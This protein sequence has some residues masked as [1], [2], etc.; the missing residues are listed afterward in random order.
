MT[1][2]SEIEQAAAPRCGPYRR[3]QQSAT[4]ASVTSQAYVDSLRSSIPSGGWENLFI[5]RRSASA[6]DRQ[7]QVSAYDP[8]T[9][10][11]QVDRLWTVAPA[12]GEYLELHHLDPA[13]ELRP[14]VLAGLRRIFFEARLNVV[15]ASTADVDLT[16]QYPWLLRPS[17]VRGLELALTGSTTSRAVRAYVGSNGHVFLSNPPADAI[18][19][20][21]QITALRPVWS[22]VNGASSTTGPTN[23]ADDLNVDADHAAAAAHIE[24]WHLFPARMRQAAEA[25]YQA[26][27]Q[28]AAVEFTRV[29]MLH[30]Q[31]TP[32]RFELS[33][34]W[35]ASSRF[36]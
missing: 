32:R 24:A 3:D 7:R 28:D 9:G 17:Q 25:G 30:R 26:S 1:A 4:Q 31:R 11:L 19:G 27:Q 14:A 36:W 12:A 6:A 21:W 35:G 20:T 23:D 13:N 18:A 2:L 33:L 5:L 15:I 10:G 16:Q 8:A 29:S 34:P 22:W